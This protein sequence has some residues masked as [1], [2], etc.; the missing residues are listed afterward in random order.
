MGLET[1]ARTVIKKSQ[2]S[3]CCSAADWCVG[4]STV[5]LALHDNFL[6]EVLQIA[7]VYMGRAQ[8]PKS[9]HVSIVELDRM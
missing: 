4:E 7:Y 9:A 1:T 5:S 8:R 6:A 3:G 2:V